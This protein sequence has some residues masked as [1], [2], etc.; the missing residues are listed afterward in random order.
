MGHPVFM[1]GTHGA[2]CDHVV[3]FFFSFYFVINVV[4]PRFCLQ[5]TLSLFSTLLFCGHVSWLPERDKTSF[6]LTLIVFL[7]IFLQ[8]KKKEA[9]DEN[10]MKTTQ[11]FMLYR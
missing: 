6:Y 2:S 11:Y 9:E 5:S 8:R 1:P 4:Q 10:L 7:L 3:I